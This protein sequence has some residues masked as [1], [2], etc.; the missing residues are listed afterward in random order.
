MILF[1]QRGCIYCEK[2]HEEVF[3][4][5]VIADYIRENF[6]VVQMDLLRRDRDHRLRRRGPVASGTP[7]ANG[8]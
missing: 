5:P 6:F 2:M 8:A 7:P 3:P 1:E 4:M